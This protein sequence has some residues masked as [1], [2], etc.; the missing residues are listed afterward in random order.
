MNNADRHAA[1]KAWFMRCMAP[2]VLAMIATGLLMAGLAFPRGLRVVIDALGT[3]M[4]NQDIRNPMIAVWLT[5]W[6]LPWPG[7]PGLLRRMLC[8]TVMMAAIPVAVGVFL[9]IR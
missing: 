6:L 7:N 1:P 4:A 9:A 8:T 2:L 3:A 5:A